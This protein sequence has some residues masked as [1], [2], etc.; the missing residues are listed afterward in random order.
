MVDFSRLAGR[1]SRVFGSASV[2]SYQA[3]PGFDTW[4]PGAIIERRPAV[5]FEGLE[6]MPAS[7][8]I[9]DATVE[10][11]LPSTTRLLAK[12]DRIALYD[13][14][15]AGTIHRV[16]RGPYVTQDGFTRYGLTEVI[17]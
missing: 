5:V 14:D 8:A 2:A 16:T 6:G 4:L 7:D 15:P 13:L 10:L 3:M 17:A 11:N 1:I 9:D 12:G